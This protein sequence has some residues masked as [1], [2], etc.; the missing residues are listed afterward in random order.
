[1]STLVFA[2]K[3]EICRASAKDRVF[4][5]VLLLSILVFYAIGFAVYRS[6]SGTW[7]LEIALLVGLYPIGAVLGFAGRWIVASPRLQL[8]LAKRIERR[9]PDDSTM[10]RLETKRL[11][12]WTK[13]AAL[14]LPLVLVVVCLVA[15]LWGNGFDIEYPRNAYVVVQLPLLAA[16]LVAVVV[17][18]TARYARWIETRASRYE[19]RLSSR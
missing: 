14:L 16:L 8:R 17:E 11:L 10:Q 12:R 18:K 9:F 7:G 2:M 19:G 3:E 15:S 4:A 6:I 5:E 13:V 1:M